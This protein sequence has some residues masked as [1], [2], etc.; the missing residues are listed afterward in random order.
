MPLSRR[1]EARRRGSPWT[2]LGTVVAKETADHLSGARM[3]VIEGLVMCAIGCAFGVLLSFFAAFAFPLIPAI[4]DMI[5]FKP[6]LRLMA[7]TIGAAFLLCAIGALW[8][9]SGATGSVMASLLVRAGVGRLRII[10][11][12]YVE[13]SNLQRQVLFGISNIGQDKVEAAAKRLRD[14]N[15]DCNIIP[16]KTIVNSSNVLE[17]IKDYDIIIDGTDNF[18]TR[19]LVN[20]ACVLLGKPNV[21]GSIFRFEGQASVF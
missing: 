20:D 4:G 11:R 9:A 19:Y 13:A 2:G 17:L 16:H 18:P 14:L 7:A 15:P 3:I 10:D 5:S 8:A 1:P 6:S 21:Y 12:D